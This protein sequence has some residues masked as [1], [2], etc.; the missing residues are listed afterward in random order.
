MIRQ[1]LS[2]IKR[3]DVLAAVSICAFLMSLATWLRTWLESRQQ[4]SI[5]LDGYAFHNNVCV[6]KLS[7][8]NESRLPVTIYRIEHVADNKVIACTRQPKVIL[9]YVRRSN[10]TV[11]DRETHKSMP[12]PIH[13]DA[14]GY[15]AGLILFEADQPA[16]SGPPTQVKIR[17]CTNRRR[18]SEFEFRMSPV[19]IQEI[20]C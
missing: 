11:I 7:F 2:N 15:A 18:S 13:L 8:I 5:F 16:P 19:D 3:E 10:N 4:L 6:F 9:E 12:I 1:L 20:V 14:L 17:L